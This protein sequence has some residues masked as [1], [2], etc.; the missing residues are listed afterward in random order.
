V[1]AVQT[2]REFQDILANYDVLAELN[3]NTMQRYYATCARGR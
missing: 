1:D 3:A 2:L